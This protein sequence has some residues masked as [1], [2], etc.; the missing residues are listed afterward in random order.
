MSG[1]PTAAEIRLRQ[2]EERRLAEE[3]R[4]KAEEERRRREEAE[5]RARIALANQLRATLAEESSRLRLSVGELR[6]AASS[7]AVPGGIPHVEA[8]IDQVVAGAGSEPESIG[9]ALGKVRAIARS[10][11][12]LG[13]NLAAQAAAAASEQETIRREAAAEAARLAVAAQSSEA[14]RH[15]ALTTATSELEIR[16]AGLQA[17]EVTMAWSGE[18]VRAVADAVASLAGS[19]A[20]TEAARELNA[21]LDAALAKAQDRQLAEERRAWIVAALQD[22]LRAQGFQ[23]GE[24]TLVGRGFDGEVAFRAV[25]SDRRWVDVNVPVEG[26]VFYDVDGTDRVTERGMDGA[27]Y[28]SCDETEARLEALHADLTDRFG[29][30]AGELFWETKDPHR[31]RRN[32]NSLPSGGP[33]ATRKQG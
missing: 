24:A 22:G 1:S 23:V 17:D 16:L 30:A 19:S 14:A 9:A 13:G 2:E 32:A 29:I 26:H 5:R 33:A 11:A 15:A 8:Q 27:A 18:E 21:R 4:R 25:R 12:T 28:T 10:I 7:A 6:A 20:P 3:R 31:K